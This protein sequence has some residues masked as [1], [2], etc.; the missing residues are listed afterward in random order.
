MSQGVVAAVRSGSHVAAVS[1]VTPYC[2]R[3]EDG[4][5]MGLDVFSVHLEVLQK[6][7]EASSKFRKASSSDL[8]SWKT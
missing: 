3:L 1:V 8:A 5:P 6:G 4:D 7:A 2:K